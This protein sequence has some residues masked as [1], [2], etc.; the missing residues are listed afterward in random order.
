MRPSGFLFF[1]K[2]LAMSSGNKK[3]ATK[4]ALKFATGMNRMERRIAQYDEERSRRE[5]NYARGRS[6]CAKKLRQKH[7]KKAGCCS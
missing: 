3:G 4:R 6:L 5:S 1:Y 7:A 2:E